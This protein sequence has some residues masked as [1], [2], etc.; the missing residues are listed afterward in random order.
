MFQQETN[1]HNDFGTLLKDQTTET[2]FKLKIIGFYGIC[3]LIFSLIFNPI[4]LFGFFKIKI[5]K[6]TSL[7]LHVI[8][9][10]VVNFLAS[11]IELPF[12]IWSNFSCR[13]INLYTALIFM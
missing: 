5:K 2:C 7:D 4:V 9:L 11:A 13:Y 1:M 8:I 3:L 10:V 12:I 6:L